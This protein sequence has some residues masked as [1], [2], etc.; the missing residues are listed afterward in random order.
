MGLLSAL[1]YTRW[2]HVPTGPWVAHHLCELQLV[3]KYHAEVPP[4]K[5]R[6]LLGGC[7]PL[8]TSTLLTQVGSAMFWCLL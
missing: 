7:F 4:W 1:I 8:L 2:A 5:E 3:G 6:V